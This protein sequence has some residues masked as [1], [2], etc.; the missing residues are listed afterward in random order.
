MEIT[1]RTKRFL[2]DLI[3]IGNWAKSCETKEQFENVKKFL[4]NKINIYKSCKT[5]EAE[6]ALYN[7]GFID[8]MFLAIEKLKFKNYE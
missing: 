1:K 8:G 2:D 6:K 5:W 4:T 3:I 7:L